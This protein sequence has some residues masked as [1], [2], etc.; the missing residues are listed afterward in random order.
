[1]A[2]HS[3]AG[4]CRYAPRCDRRSAHCEALRPALEAVDGRGDR[5]CRCWRPL[6]HAA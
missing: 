3:L 4:G 6:E 2:V 1:P 5:A